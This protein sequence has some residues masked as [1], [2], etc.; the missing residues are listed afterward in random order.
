MRNVQPRHP[1]SSSSYLHSSASLPGL[2][3]AVSRQTACA[4]SVINPF[5]GMQMGA[6]VQAK[7]LS[8]QAPAYLTATGLALRGFF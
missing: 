7:R 6:N 4:C 8:K 3:Q 5:D 2:T 1:D